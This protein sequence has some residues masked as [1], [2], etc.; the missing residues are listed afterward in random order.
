M[1]IKTL[2]SNLCFHPSTA[3]TVLKV[4]HHWQI[5]SISLSLSFSLSL[6]L[7]LS[8]SP[9]N[10]TLS[11]ALWKTFYIFKWWRNTQRMTSIDLKYT[12]KMF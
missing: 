12:S 4:Y 3:L 10:I 1:A 6:S 5:R 11:L 9:H 7:S 2:E 8:L